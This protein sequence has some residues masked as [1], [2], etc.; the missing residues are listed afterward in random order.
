MTD[1]TLDAIRMRQVEL[2]KAIMCLYLEAHQDVAKDVSAKAQAV[3]ADVDTL[4]DRLTAEEKDA[5]ARGFKEGEMKQAI[6]EIQGREKFKVEAT[7]DLQAK[8]AACEASLEH[9]KTIVIPALTLMYDT[10]LA[11]AR[12]ALA[13]VSTVLRATTD[14]TTHRPGCEK[15]T[16]MNCSCGFDLHG[17]VYRQ[18]MAQ[19]EAA[20]KEEA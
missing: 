2:R 18:A 16:A 6:L 20:L 3:L 10:K 19:A 9:Q 1:P 12:A 13:A 17:A 15:L 11:Q 7:R 14:F 5:F 8:L 4:L